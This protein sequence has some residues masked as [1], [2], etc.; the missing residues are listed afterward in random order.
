MAYLVVVRLGTSSVQEAT[1]KKERL[2]QQLMETDPQLNTR[3]SLGNLVWKR[4]EEGL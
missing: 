1:Q 3:W 4:G 2:H